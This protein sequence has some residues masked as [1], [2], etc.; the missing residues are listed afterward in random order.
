VVSV[1]H[2]PNGSSQLGDV[3]LFNGD[4][5]F[6]EHTFSSLPFN[7]SQYTLWKMKA[8]GSLVN[9]GLISNQWQFD[10]DFT[11][12]NGELYFQ[13][14][15]VS[16]G[17]EL[18]KVKA[19]GT[20]VQVADIDPGVD[21]SSPSGFTEFNGELYFLASDGSSSVNLWKVK[22]DGSVVQLADPGSGL[23]AREGFA[24]YNGEL[25]FEA[26][27][28][29]GT[30]LWKVKAD[31]SVAEVGSISSGFVSEPSSFCVCNG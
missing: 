7:I 31:G 5:Y 13:S 16:T 3:T 21:S 23:S 24:Q 26:E 20:V 1:A 11:P 12:F 22:A 4:L 8:D 15:R 29:H 14:D 27:D 9:L 2:V 10:P 18:W 17:S 28:A 6:T 19:D 30:E 25:Y